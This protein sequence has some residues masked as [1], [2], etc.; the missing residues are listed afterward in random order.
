MA[1]PI[2]HHATELPLHGGRAP[3]WLFGRMVRLSGA[4]SEVILDDF[5]GRNVRPRRNRGHSITEKM[6]KEK[7]IFL[8]FNPLRSRGNS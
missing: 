5:G 6:L 7:K 4:I 1:N 3:R 2:M 8:D